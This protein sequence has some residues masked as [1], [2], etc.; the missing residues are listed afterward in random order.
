MLEANMY[1]INNIFLTIKILKLYHQ[2]R[3]WNEIV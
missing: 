2:T 3:N 1:D